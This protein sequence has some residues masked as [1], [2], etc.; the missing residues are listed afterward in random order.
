M[1]CESSRVVKC[2][3]GHGWQ[4]NICYVQSV[5]GIA[6][7][8]ANW[9]IKDI[10]SHCVTFNQHLTA[11]HE[12][13]KGL[14]SSGHIQFKKQHRFLITC[15]NRIV[16]HLQFNLQSIECKMLIDSKNKR[17][18]GNIKYYKESCKLT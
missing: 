1:P 5:L 6:W 15:F 14:D 17:K 2:P 12:L 4:S 16:C 11:T 10:T 3:I 8:V 9:D 18:H 7:V 13:R